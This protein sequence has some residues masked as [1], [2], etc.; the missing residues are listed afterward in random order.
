MWVVWNNI[1]IIFPVIKM[2]ARNGKNI[3]IK[4]FENVARIAQIVKTLIYVYVTML[5]LTA[6]FGYSHLSDFVMSIVFTGI[7]WGVG[8]LILEYTFAPRKGV[9]GETL[10]SRVKSST[11]SSN[12]RTFIVAFMSLWFLTSMIFSLQIIL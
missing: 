3:V 11:T 1:R 4:L 9:N 5:L 8:L 12:K 10:P 2:L 7:M 6:I